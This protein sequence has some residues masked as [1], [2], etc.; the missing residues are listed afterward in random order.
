MNQERR[1]EQQMNL[2]HLDLPLGLRLRKARESVPYG[3]FAAA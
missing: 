2:P 1:E 3:Q